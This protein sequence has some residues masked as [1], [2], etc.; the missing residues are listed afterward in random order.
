M[1]AA[2]P[3]QAMG[4]GGADRM[5]NPGEDNLA[6]RLTKLEALTDTGLT[7]LGVD[8]FLEEMLVRVR[9]MLDVDTAVVLLLDA[10]SDE[11]VARAASGIEEE[12]RQGVRV[13]VG[14]GF[15]GR[16][17]RTREPTRLDRVDSTTVA[18]PILWEK[19]IKVMLGVPLLSEDAVLGVLHVGRT[20]NRPFDDDDLRLLQVVGERIAAAI[21]TRRWRSNGQRPCCSNAACCRRHSRSA[22][23]SPLL[24]GSSP[25]RIAQSA[26]IGTTSSYFRLASCGWW[27]AMS[28]VMVCK[29]RW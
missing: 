6:G 25:P 29:P 19:G 13:P 5:L 14:V 28:Q 3:K 21:H 20:A 27:L 15:A 10:N 17:A 16:V 23:G 1:L 4:A 7:R 12:V 22:R 11:L 9:E 26:A 2:V 8:D 18:N 24:F